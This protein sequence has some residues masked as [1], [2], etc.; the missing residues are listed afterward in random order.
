MFGAKNNGY[1]DLD[2]V[3]SVGDVAGRVMAG[4]LMKNQAAR[5]RQQQDH[6]RRGDRFGFLTCPKC[7]RL[8]DINSFAVVS[9]GQRV[10]E[11]YCGKCRRAN[12][13]AQKRGRK[14]KLKQRNRLN[15]S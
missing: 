11:K 9:G 7:E 13:I 2:S 12:L 3:G 4:R 8:L 6:Y 10:I 1:R 14:R 15:P 5:E